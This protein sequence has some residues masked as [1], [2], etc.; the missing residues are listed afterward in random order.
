MLQVPVTCNPSSHDEASGD[1]M[2]SLIGMAEVLESAFGA[3]VQPI[4]SSS[5]TSHSVVIEEVGEE[6]GPVRGGG[7]AGGIE[8]G[9]SAG[10]SG[11]HC[12]M[13]GVARHLGTGLD[14]VGTKAIHSNPGFSIRVE[15]SEE[16]ELAAGSPRRAA[17]SDVQLSP[18]KAGEPPRSHLP[19]HLQG[20]PGAMRRMSRL[21]FV[22]SPSSTLQGDQLECSGLPCHASNVGHTHT[23]ASTAAAA[24]PAG[25][26]TDPT[27]PVPGPGAGYDAMASAPAL[28]LTSRMQSRQGGQGWHAPSSP[29]PQRGVGS[30]VPAPIIEFSEMTS[31]EQNAFDDGDGEEED[32]TSRRLREMSASVGGGDASTSAQMRRLISR[33][34][35]SNTIK[36]SL[37]LERRQPQVSKRQLRHMAS[38]DNVPRADTTANALMR[39][40]SGGA[41]GTAGSW[42][43]HA[44]ITLQ[45]AASGSL[46]ANTPT[47]VTSFHNAQ[48]R[49]AF[50]VRQSMDLHRRPP[51]IASWVWGKGAGLRV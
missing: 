2:D 30:S 27:G 33:S 3:A 11:L 50:V 8:G 36:G 38:Q 47:S 17:Y 4:A 41:G 45:S 16:D 13:E 28:T 49:R 31:D 39:P 10:P 12:I 34:A 44:P 19:S 26:S 51:T 32:D 43:G 37:D 40:K 21:A 1:L 6:L 23:A 18:P 25:S 5:S 24:A 14:G 29:L 7:A 15:P 9:G 46:A 35:H 22:G 48:Q 20:S 42:G